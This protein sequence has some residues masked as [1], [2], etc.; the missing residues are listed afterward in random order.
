MYL[1]FYKMDIGIKK[2]SSS[3]LE[4]VCEWINE[5]VEDRIIEWLENKGV[6]PESPS[7]NKREYFDSV[8][9]G[10]SQVSE[11]EV[12]RQQFAPLN[13]RCINSTK[14]I[15][16]SY[17]KGNYPLKQVRNCKNP[18][19]VG[20]KRDSSMSTDLDIHSLNNHMSH[21]SI[22]SIQKSSLLSRRGFVLA[23]PLSQDPTSP[24]N[25]YI[26]DRTLVCSIIMPEHESKTKV[27]KLNL[28]RCSEVEHDVPSLQTSTYMSSV[29]TVED[30]FSNKP[31]QNETNEIRDAMGCYGR[32]AS[33][34]ISA[35]ADQTE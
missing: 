7:I 2:I 16:P 4:S 5:E 32:R 13:K 17:P 11:K 31:S 12:F 35:H 25:K 33:N 1:V 27:I 10:I 22:E 26:P 6:Y 24:S 8:K 23:D 21:K 15:S 9:K 18:T 28:N 20:I 3:I 19:V 34:F 29:Q 14:V 30:I